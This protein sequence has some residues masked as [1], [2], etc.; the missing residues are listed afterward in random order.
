L[1]DSILKALLLTESKVKQIHR[2]EI[3]MRG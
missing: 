1:F 2:S 3:D